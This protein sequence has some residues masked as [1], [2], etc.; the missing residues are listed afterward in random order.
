MGT[1]RKSLNGWCAGQL[2]NSRDFY[3]YAMVLYK[4][5]KK[6]RRFKASSHLIKIGRLI[7]QYS[8][9]HEKYTTLNNYR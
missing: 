3:R 2:F 9:A 5:T 7:V 1:R 8:H 4:R 6:L